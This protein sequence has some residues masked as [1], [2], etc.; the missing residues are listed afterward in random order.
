MAAHNWP[1]DAPIQKKSRTCGT[2]GMTASWV[3]TDSYVNLWEMSWR[4][5][6]EGGYVKGLRNVPGCTTP[7]ASS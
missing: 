7:T 1:T 4:R 3:K 5:G 2:C 6:E